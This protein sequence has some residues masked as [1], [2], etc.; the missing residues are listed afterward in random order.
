MKSGSELSSKGP[1]KPGSFAFL[2]KSF[3][4]FDGLI[5]IKEGRAL[6]PKG[7]FSML[8][9]LKP[10]PEHLDAIEAE[11]CRL[12]QSL[13][14][15]YFIDRFQLDDY[16]IMAALFWL[17]EV[18]RVKLTVLMVRKDCRLLIVNQLERTNRI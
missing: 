10:N 17:E 5:Y 3:P 15:D 1:G 7:D 18:G 12:G 8:S 11:L 4:L 6:M 13:T 16:E 9:N 2:T 14:V